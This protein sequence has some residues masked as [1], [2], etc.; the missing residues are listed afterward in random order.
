MYFFLVY[1]NKMNT[2]IRKICYVTLT[3]IEIKKILSETKKGQKE[4][5]IYLKEFP[6]D[7]KQKLNVFLHCH[8]NFQ[9]QHSFIMNKLKES[10]I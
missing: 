8:S 4:K 9:K 10:E 1:I 6:S 2:D 3:P 7:N 5:T